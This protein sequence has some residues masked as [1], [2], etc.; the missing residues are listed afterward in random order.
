MMTIRRFSDEDQSNVTELINS[1]MNTEFGDSQAAYPSEDIQDIPKTYGGLG[2]A[3]FVAI[4]GDKI[5]GTIAVKKEDPRIAIMRRLFVAPSHRKQQLGLQLIQRALQFCDEVG[6]REIVFR[7]T[8]KMVGAIK[9]CQKCGFVQRA[10]LQMGSVE[11]LKFSL[12][13]RNGIRRERV[14]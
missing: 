2:E 10:K 3:F 8:S 9:I 11:L 1:I 12:S 14:A 13:L 4:N 5:V 7:T 6:Y